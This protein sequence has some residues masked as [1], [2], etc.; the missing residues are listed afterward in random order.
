MGRI[1]AAAAILSLFTSIAAAADSGPAFPRTPDGKPDFSGLYNIPY[2]PNMALNKEQDVPYTEL[3]RQAYLNHDSKDDPTANCW[4]PGVPRIMQSP[5]PARI[6]QTHDYLV[7]LFEYETMFR[8]IPLDGRRHAD[9][10]EPSFMGDSVGHWEGD[11]IVVDTTNLKGPPWT[12]LDTAGHQHSDELHV[13]ERFRPGSNGKVDYEFTVDDPKMYS[14]P[15]VHS[16]PL[17][18]LKATPGLPDLIEYN[19]AENN[20]D[21]GHLRSFKPAQPP[22]AQK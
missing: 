9:K 16:R 12:W 21:L 17:T 4:F 2:T 18:P 11:T 13:I 3:G 8:L 5:Y 1:V 10:M 7:I 19:C 15:W 14:K 20:K 6:V 22:A